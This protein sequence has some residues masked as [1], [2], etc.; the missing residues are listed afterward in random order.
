MK[1]GI[2]WQD[3]KYALRPGRGFIR[4]PSLVLDLP[5]YKLDGASFMSKDAYGH[6]CTVTGALCRPNGRIFDGDD[7]ISVANVASLNITGTI[8][9]EAWVKAD[10][11]QSTS[12]SIVVK[13]GTSPYYFYGLRLV[14]SRL[15]MQISIDGSTY[16]VDVDANY[17]ANTWTHVVGLYD[18]SNVKLYID[19]VVQAAAPAASGAIDVGNGVL[20]IASW[21]TLE[22]F[23]GYIG[24][25][26]I[27]NRGL[28]P[29]EIQH[30]YLATK[31]RYR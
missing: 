15:R 4:D 7:R 5:L 29:L 18:G 23:E 16:G 20:T 22:Y 30:S 19:M 21:Q 14:G 12:R 17:T 1:T 26:R 3:P 2:Y 9:V 25:V 6:L 10:A 11:G 31:W 8:T 28:T 27:Y 13:T 24:E